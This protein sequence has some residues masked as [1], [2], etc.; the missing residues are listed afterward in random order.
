[1][2]QEIGRGGTGASLGEVPGI[3]KMNPDKYFARISCSASFNYQLT[4]VEHYFG[5]NWG[6]ISG[7]PEVNQSDSMAVVGLAIQV[8]RKVKC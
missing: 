8:N 7:K 4:T 2:K 1:L 6:I 5:K 3:Q